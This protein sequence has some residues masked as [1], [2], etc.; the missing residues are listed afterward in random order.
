MIVNNKIPGM[1]S[2]NSLE[3]NTLLIISFQFG[4]VVKGEE[5]P[6]WDLIQGEVFSWIK[7]DNAAIPAETLGSKTTLVLFR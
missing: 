2:R 1:A 5:D 6:S 7:L 3:A 4:S